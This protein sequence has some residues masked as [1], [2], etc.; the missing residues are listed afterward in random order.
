M[1]YSVHVLKMAEAE[2]PGPEVYWMSH[3]QEWVRLYFYMVVVQGNGITAVVNTGPPADLSEMNRAWSVFAGPRCQMKRLEEQRPKNALASIGIDPAK[4]DFVLLTP[5]QAYATANISLFPNAQICCSRRGWIE[6][7]VARPP[8]LH[9]PRP[10]CIPDPVLHHLLFEARDRVRLLEDEEEICSGIHTW[11]AGT[12]H[13]SSVVYSFE[14]DAGLVMTGD[15]AMKYGN[16]DGHPLGIAESI[17]EG[18]VA[19]RRIRREA[20]IFLPLY[21]PEVLDRYPG[22]TVA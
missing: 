22:G 18:E 5:L 12:H 9:V 16:I 7:I 2:V 3:W 13:R 17:L 21:E 14:T 10:L 11:W 4:V 1:S 20:S 19:Y 15:C 6:D 8:G